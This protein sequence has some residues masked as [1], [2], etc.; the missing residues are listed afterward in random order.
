MRTLAISLA[1][2][3]VYLLLDYFASRYRGTPG[4]AISPWYLPQGIVLGLLVIGGIRY[5]PTVFL[6]CLLGGLV[7]WRFSPA[8]SVGLALAVTLGYWLVAAVLR[9]VV[10]IDPRL[11]RLRDAFNLLLVALIAP[12]PTAALAALTFALTGRIGWGEYGSALAGWWYGDLIGLFSLTPFM[13]VHGAPWARTLIRSAASLTGEKLAEREA[14]SVEIPRVTLKGLFNVIVWTAIIAGTV[15]LTMLSPMAVSRFFYLA[16]L[17][18]IWIALQHGMRGTSAGVMGFSMGT[19]AALLITAFVTQQPALKG[20]FEY[21]TG[22]NAIAVPEL[23]IFIFALAVTGLL[24]GAVV[25]ERRR[26][27][28]A[29]RDSEELL[30]TFIDAMP[31]MVVFKDGEGRWLAAN[32]FGQ[33][34]FQFDGTPYAGKT[35]TELAEASPLFRDVLLEDERMDEEAWE[36]GSPSR[37]EEVIPQPDGSRMTFDVIK[38]PL[39]HPDGSRKG[40]VVI[41]RDITE[42]KLAEEALDRERAYLSSAIDILPLPLAFLAPN[43]EWTQANA[44]SYAFVRGLLPRQWLDGQMLTPDTRMLIPREERPCMRSLEEVVPTSTEVILILPDG[45]EVPMLVHSGPVTVNGKLVAVVAAFQDITAIREAERAKDEF[46]GILSHEL[47]TPLTDALGWTQAARETPDSTAQALDI[48]EHNVRLLHRVMTD[49]LDLSRII[50]GKLYLSREVTDLWALTEKYAAEFE[51]IATGRRRALV[52][53]APDEELPVSLD[54]ERLRQVLITLFD[55]ALKG[56]DPGDKIIVTG[57]AE[58]DTAVLVIRDTGHGMPQDT[59]DHLFTPFYQPQPIEPG[60]GMGLGL[61][62]VKGLIELHGGRISADSPGLDQGTI[63]T[64]EL[65]LR[66]DD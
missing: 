66:I 14:E 16:F 38:M 4:G 52:L 36:Q 28:Q 58:G 56:T 3:A 57:R 50:H 15:W 27:E 55:N 19:L 22:E 41:G 46:L 6:G 30:R 45:R 5:A 43:G 9:H 48:I 53:E 51:P 23:Q 29:V 33:R 62:L 20:K 34:L 10:K 32:N 61:S 39:L 60:R 1:Y 11:A 12:L 21:L 59:L 44:A 37:A 24:L 47:L 26:T 35:G 54:R 25:S 13:L 7:F 17:V 18:I 40:M 31:D 8:T 65:P 2:L 64:I 49:L 63:F 42:R